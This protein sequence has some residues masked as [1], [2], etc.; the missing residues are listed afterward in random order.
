MRESCYA[1]NRMRESLSKTVRER[2][3]RE[4]LLL[5]ESCYDRNKSEESATGESCCQRNKSDRE[6]LG[7]VRE[8]LMEYHRETRGGLVTV[9]TSLIGSVVGAQRECSWES[10]EVLLESLVA[11][12]TSL[13]GHYRRVSLGLSES[14]YANSPRRE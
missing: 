10:R 1:R 7:R 11:T 14:C 5:P 3:S 4:S 9:V 12:A 13:R 6:S 8:S 2:P